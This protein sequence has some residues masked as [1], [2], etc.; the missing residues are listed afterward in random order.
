[1]IDAVFKI[2][3]FGDAGSGK[4][5]LT[6]RFM[7]N[8]FI[9]DTSTTI[10]VDLQVKSLKVLGMNVK[11]QIWDFGGEER[12]RFFLPSYCRGAHGGVFL[13]DITS[14]D[15]LN[16]MGEWTE[17]VYDNAGRIPILLVGAKSDLEEHRAVS[18]GEGIDVAKGNDLVGFVETSS[19]T[20]ENVEISFETIAKLMFEALKNKE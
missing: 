12:F 15:S 4:T 19:K 5:T 7:T 14:K 16:H 13:Y 8:K 3:I 11:L 2:C 9:S 17:L 10:G 6:K 18:K 20:G 1:M